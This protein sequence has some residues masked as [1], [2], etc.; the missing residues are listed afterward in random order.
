[1]A[2]CAWELNMAF[3]YKDALMNGINLDQCGLLRSTGWRA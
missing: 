1:M 2:G 3:A